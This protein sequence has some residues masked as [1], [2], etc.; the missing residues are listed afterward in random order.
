[1]DRKT[2]HPKTFSYADAS[3]DG[4]KEIKVDILLHASLFL[5]NIPA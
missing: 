5:N 4:I 3:P 1:M 2:W